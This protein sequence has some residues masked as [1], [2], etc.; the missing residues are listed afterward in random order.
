ML[1]INGC[2]TFISLARNINPVPQ[3]NAASWLPESI[4]GNA[5][6]ERGGVHLWSLI[7]GALVAAIANGLDAKPLKVIREGHYEREVRIPRALR[8]RYVVVDG[9]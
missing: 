9:G 5:W 6:M 4:V 1:Q 7:E 3:W 8:S 2:L